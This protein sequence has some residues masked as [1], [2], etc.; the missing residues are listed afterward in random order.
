MRNIFYILGFI[1]IFGC[2]SESAVLT[3]ESDYSGEA[4]LYNTVTQ[5]IDT[6]MSSGSGFFINSLS[7]ES[8]TLFYLVFKDINDFSRPFFLI[9]SNQET[10]IKFNDLI[11]IICNTQNYNDCYPNRPLF[12]SD[13]NK[14]EEFYKFHDLWIQFSN[15]VIKPEL[16]IEA[17]KG[18]YESFIS[19]SEKLIIED[20]D[21]YVSASIIDFLMNNNLIQLDKIQLFYSYLEPDIKLSFIGQKIKKEAGFDIQTPAPKFSFQDFNGINYSLDSLIGKKVLLHFWSSTC[22][23][24]VKEIPALKEL[25]KEDNGLVIV[26]IS[27]DTDKSRWISGMERLGI[28][29]MINFCD[30]NGAKGRICQDYHIKAIPANYLIDEKGNIV[31]KKETL[32]GIKAKL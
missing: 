30:F 28:I 14:N 9:L 8:P 32:Q 12:L 24:C 20:K 15:N 31:V 2:K 23:P 21:L 17:R 13:P 6:I 3:I 1:T 18:L 27:L 26:N 4:Y 19:T 11:P 10:Q 22:A 7:L 29:D 5:K 25:A 16:D